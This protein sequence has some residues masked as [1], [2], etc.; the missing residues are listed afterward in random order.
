ML[1]IIPLVLAPQSLANNTT[2]VNT[3]TGGVQ[4]LTIQSDGSNT[5]NDLQLELTRNVT[6]QDAS[7][8][9]KFE[10]PS[11]SPGSVSINNSFGDKIWEFNSPGVWK[12]ILQNSFQSGYT[13]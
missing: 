7:F 8:A 5:S 6:Y 12:L 2:E 9:V 1:L 10:N 11:Q 3:F 13:L 4:S